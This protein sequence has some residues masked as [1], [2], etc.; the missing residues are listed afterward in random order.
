MCVWVVYDLCPHQWTAVA[1]FR[2]TPVAFFRHEL[3]GQLEQRPAMQ[4][5][6]GAA[7]ENVVILKEPRSNLRQRPSHE[8]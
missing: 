4:I 6:T 8:L 2:R 3:A 1:F 7:N 5:D